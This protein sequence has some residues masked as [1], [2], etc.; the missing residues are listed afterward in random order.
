M[1]AILPH[2][3]GRIILRRFARDDL[4]AF[5]AYRHDPH[6]GQYQSWTAQSDQDALHFID[7]VAAAPLFT[8]GEWSQ[9]AVACRD[10]ALIG[11]IGVCID[12]AS[13]MAELGVSLSLAAQGG[14]LAHD[15]CQ[16]ACALIFAH[17]PVLRIVAIS[18]VRNEAAHALALRLGFV[19]QETTETVEDGEAFVE[20]V[21]HLARP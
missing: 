6:V 16:A 2:R 15:A 9:I 1:T 14:G 21:F 13:E 5:Q 3:A 12:A 18:D 19:Y 20:K 7:A 17:T 11:D 4:A 8:P 10:G